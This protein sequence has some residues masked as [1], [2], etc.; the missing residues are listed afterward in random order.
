M[1]LPASLCHTLKGTA[2]KETTMNISRRIITFSVF[3]FFC[4]STIAFAGSRYYDY[5]RHYHKPYHHTY[6]HRNNY[7][8]SSDYFWAFLGATVLTGVLLHSLNSRP[9][10]RDR[11]LYGTPG[12]STRAQTP[13]KHIF[14]SSQPIPPTELILRRVETTAHLL[15]IRS[16]PE[17]S[18]D[19]IEQ[20]PLGT[21][22]GVIGAAPD[23]LYIKTDSGRYG[24]IMEQYTRPAG[25]PVG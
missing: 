24:W 6:K 14:V 3:L 16:I 23:W 9:P 1:H 2:S 5:S 21:V 11:V 8:G 19:I 20:L 13:P 4:S 25:D 22:I 18:A 7:S 10:A 15:N 17:P 12:Y